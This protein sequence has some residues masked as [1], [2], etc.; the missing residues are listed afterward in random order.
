MAQAEPNLDQ[1]S[2]RQLVAAAV[3]GDSE[4]LESLVR[5]HQAWIYN[6]ALRMVGNA[7]DAEDVTQ[8]ILYK[9]VTHLATFQGKSKFRTWLYRIVANHVIN[10][11]RRPMEATYSFSEYG[12]SIDRTPD[13]DFPDDTSHEIDRDL[14]AEETRHICLAGMLLCLN[15]DQRLAF[16][17]GAMFGVND[18]V[19]SEIVG[20]SRTAYRK[21]LSRAR[22][23]IREFME[24]RCSLYKQG[25]SCTCANKTPALVGAGRIDP[26]NLK[27]SH[28]SAKKVREAMPKRLSSFRDFWANRCEELFRDE[29]YYEPED[30]VDSIRELTQEPEFKD[31]FSLN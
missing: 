19:G 6:V 24:A 11:K 28:V 13:L 18:R 23:R 29:I 9:V 7:H 10:M 22:Q 20:T 1:M 3:Q 8:E 14:L 12:P 16:I 17:L 2:D 15:R 27:F 30:F 26:S 25:S 21:R 4:S 5:K 31:V